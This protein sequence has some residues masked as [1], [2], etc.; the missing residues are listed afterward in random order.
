MM[1][2]I[3]Y[4][5]PG[6]N[7]GDKLKTGIKKFLKAAGEASRMARDARVSNP[8]AENVRQLYNQG[9]KQNAKDLAGA[10]LLGST[11]G[12]TLPLAPW[13]VGAGGNLASLGMA[14]GGLAGAEAT[15]SVAMANASQPYFSDIEITPNASEVSPPIIY[16][17]DENGYIPEEVVPDSLRGKNFN[18]YVDDYDREMMRRKLWDDRVYKNDYS[19]DYRNL[20]YDSLNHKYNIWVNA[21]ED[22]TLQKNNPQ[23]HVALSD[24]L[25]DDMRQ[26]ETKNADVLATHFPNMAKYGTAK[27]HNYPKAAE[28]TTLD[29]ANYP[30]LDSWIKA[31]QAEAT[32]VA[33]ERSYSR[34]YPYAPY[35]YNGKNTDSGLGLSCMATAS[36]NFGG[37][38]L[39]FTNQQLI[40]NPQK[41]GFR[42][43]SEGE[44]PIAGDLVSY[45][46]HAAI[47]TGKY[48]GDNKMLTN[49]SSGGDSST[50]MRKE[51]YY[52]RNPSYLF[53]F[54]GLPEDSVRW[55]NEYEFKKQGGTLNYLTF[56]K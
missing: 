3:Q 24:S 22:S 27:F 54:V 36:S 2:Y 29:P 19:D 53:E 15:G 31:R 1:N 16:E 11:A 37:P 12:L 6:G 41:Y 49:Y 17:E 25:W 44:K 52:G 35:Y 51:A 5:K 32:S 13:L 18:G 40:D 42:L 33:L 28:R 8:G 26:Y 43:R 34:R 47:F 45:G 55:A 7:F 30:T 20:V 10:Y 39:C 23:Y 48:R 38:Y 46:G 14:A 56:F 9:D 50:S 21:Y 4:M